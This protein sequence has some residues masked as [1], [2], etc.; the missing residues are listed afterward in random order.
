MAMAD[1]LLLLPIADIEI[2][3]RIAVRDDAHITH[4]A[5]LFRADGQR[6]PIE[7]AKR[8]PG[9]ARPWL[10]VA[11]Y[12]R[13]HAAMAAGLS[14]IAAYQVADENATVAQLKLIELSENVDHRKHRPIDLSILIAARAELELAV[15]YPDG[16]NEPWYMRASRA[17]WDKGADAGD[18]ISP[19]PE[20]TLGGAVATVAG[21]SDWQRRT[22]IAF[23]MADRTLRGY[24]AINRGLAA[25]FPDHISALNFHPVLEGFTS[26]YRLAQIE[27]EPDRRKVVELLVANTEVKTLDQA[28]TDAGV[29]TSKGG[30]MPEK[31]R[32]V[33]KFIT[34]WQRMTISEKLAE[35]PKF[36]VTITPSV[37]TLI[38]KNLERDAAKEMLAVLQKRGLN[39]S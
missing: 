5:G 1:E 15:D 37:A 3:E 2:G 13:I 38:A 21:A 28:M 36:A 23:G 12:H 27:N 18:T 20:D 35:A 32:A 26:A 30:R 34:G 17:R 11:G 8:G 39:L 31:D 9:A 4:L 25:V 29:S 6:D 24:L 7:V 33:T 14:D 10:L 19:A 16:A 22:A